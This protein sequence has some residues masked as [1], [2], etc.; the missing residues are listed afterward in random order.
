MGRDYRIWIAAAPRSTRSARS[1]AR[2]GGRGYRNHRKVWRI[3]RVEKMRLVAVLA[4]ILETV[5]EHV[6]SALGTRRTLQRGPLPDIAVA[7]CDGN[8]IDLA[9]PKQAFDA[10]ADKA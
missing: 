8:G 4:R 10:D 5:E 2:S 1:L 9:R 3:L 7:D 6:E